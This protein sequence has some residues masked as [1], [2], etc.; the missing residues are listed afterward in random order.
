MRE[1]KAY[2]GIAQQL[3][4]AEHKTLELQMRNQ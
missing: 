2:K 1:V 3:E 4:R